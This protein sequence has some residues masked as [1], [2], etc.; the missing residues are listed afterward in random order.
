MDAKLLEEIAEREALLDETQRRA[1]QAMNVADFCLTTAQNLE[2]TL[3]AY[4]S[5][6]GNADAS[7]PP[8]FGAD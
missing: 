5:F 3:T 4:Q 6:L 8:S 2:Q 1:D 7:L